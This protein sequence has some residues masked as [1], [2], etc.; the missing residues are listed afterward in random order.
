MKFL[1]PGS[2]DNNISVNKP[3]HKAGKKKT[4]QGSAAPV[5]GN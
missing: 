1:P 4:F 2:H 5:A 3:K